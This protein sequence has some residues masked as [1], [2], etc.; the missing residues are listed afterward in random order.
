MRISLNGEEYNCDTKADEAVATMNRNGHKY[1][2]AILYGDFVWV[3]PIDIPRKMAVAIL[4]QNSSSV[5]VFSVTGN[6]AR[7]LCESLG[8]A[9][10]PQSHGAPPKYLYHYHGRNYSHA[11]SWYI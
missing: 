11:H 3:A 5:G 10:G 1:Y 4:K 6:L 9:I 2:P 8:G 7:D